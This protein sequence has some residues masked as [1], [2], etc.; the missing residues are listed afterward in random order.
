MYQCALSKRNMNDEKARITRIKTLL[1]TAYPNA[2]IMLTY[3]TPWE[4]LVAVMLSAQCTDSMVNKVTPT[5][6]RIFPTMQDIANAD[7]KKLE[8]TI[9]PTGFYR[10]KA[11]HII[12]TAKLLVEKFNGTV[13]DTMEALIT[14]P[15]VA[16]KTANVVLY[17]AFHKQVGIAVDTHVLRLSERLHLVSKNAYGNPTKTEQELMNRLNTEEWGT[18][19]YKLIDHGRAICQAKRPLCHRCVLAEVCPSAFLF[20]SKKHDR[21]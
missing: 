10:N 19:T 13:P 14:L 6:F 5:L 8:L 9:R 12:A 20:D 11:G 15:G 18:I 7:P 1:T 3:T 2:H 16:R 21:M 17:N 4:L